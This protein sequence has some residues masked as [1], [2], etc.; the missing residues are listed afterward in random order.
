MNMIFSK[1]FFGM[2][3]LLAVL[4][5]LVPAT[6]AGQGHETSA[7]GVSEEHE[8]AEHAYHVNHFGGFMGA[9]TPLNTDETGFTLGLEYA[10]QFHPRWAV[11]GYTEL[12]SGTDERDII[13]AAGIIFY[14]IPRVGLVLAPGFE[15]VEKDVEVHGEI[16]KE[17]EK[18]LLLRV[19]VGYGFPLGEAA[20]GPA[21]FADYAGDRWT[22]VYGVAMVTGF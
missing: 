10:R 6:V 20:I 11:V 9:S 13:F 7:D 22:I 21:V 18:E 19:G 4:V 12:V 16:E 3:A 8:A 2:T 17:N 14:P 15:F 5:F 1:H